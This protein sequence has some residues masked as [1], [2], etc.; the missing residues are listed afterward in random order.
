MSTES[1]TPILTETLTVFD[2]AGRPLTTNEVAAELPIGR[3]STYERLQRLVEH[4]YLATKKVGANGRI[5]WRPSTDTTHDEPPDET[6]WGA[7]YDGHPESSSESARSWFE[8]LFERS[9]DMIDVL[10]PDGRLLE[11]NQ[12]LCAE[13]G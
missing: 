7:R 9:P 5:W 2:P 3:R 11:V 13:L 10:D 6:S 4:D 12:R 1:L 8:A